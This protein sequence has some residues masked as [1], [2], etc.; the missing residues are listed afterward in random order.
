MLYFPSFPM[1]D[2]RMPIRLT[3]AIPVILLPFAAFAADA[4]PQPPVTPAAVVVQAPA[5][6]WRAIAPDTLLVMTLEGGKRIVIQLAPRFAPAH[7]ANIRALARAG[8]WDGESIYRVQ[9]NY[10]AQWG[11][12]TE[13]KPLPAGIATDIRPD[14]VQPAAPFRAGLVPMPYPD[15]YAPH[16]G[17]ADGWPVA[18]DD[19]SIW[20]PHCYGMVGVARNLSPDAGTGA[21]LYAVIGQ[22]PR[23]LD[24]NIAVAGR[25]I[26]GMSLLASLPRGSGDLGFYTA[27]ERRLDILSVRLASDLPEAE[28]P[29]FEVMDT[30]SQSFA[31][32]LRLRANRQDDFYNRPAGGVDLCNA[33]V[34]VRRKPEA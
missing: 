16:T 33:P 8:W 15:S 11:D 9:D 32:Y 5:S 17:F 26:E 10:V 19:A 6:A 34:P 7:A 1:L 30:G 18:M 24:R 14:Y 13:K 23:Q 20:L 25:V 4:P 31:D 29:H 3:A 27:G 2:Q 28:R 21:E 12:V 22:A